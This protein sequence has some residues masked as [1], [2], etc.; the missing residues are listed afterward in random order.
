MLFFKQLEIGPMANYV[1][2]IGD[3]EKKLCA[4][5][6]PAWEVPAILDQ[7]EREG[8]HLTS[9]LVT[10]NHF[11]HCNGVGDLL[12]KV[13]IPVYVNRE[14]APG[15][16]A[17]G[18]N[19]KP[20]EGGDK[21]GVGSIEISFLHT[22]GHTAGSQCL[23]VGGRLVT[24]DTLFIG[25]CGR[26]D[27]PTSDPAQMYESLRKISGLPPE[28]VIWPGHNYAEDPSAPLKR[29]LASNPYLKTAARGLEDF[30]KLVGS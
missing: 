4:V 3:S 21:I 18:E 12:K 6:D 11:D 16:K 2:L 14:D 22:P 9:A 29:E 5:V 23:K 8:Y 13:D 20:V 15:V 27:L 26:V 7:V 25:G 1:Y 19:L 17:A 28:T 24:G 10:H 30:L